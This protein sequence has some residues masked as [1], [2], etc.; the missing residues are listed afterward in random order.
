MI[1]SVVRLDSV[2]RVPAASRLVAP[3]CCALSS[4]GN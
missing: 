3:C 4:G 2:V 1:V